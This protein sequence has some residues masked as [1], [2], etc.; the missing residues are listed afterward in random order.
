VNIFFG[1]L[2]NQRA[3]ID[4]SPVQEEETGRVGVKEQQKEDARRKSINPMRL[5]V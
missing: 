5:T 1:Y 3:D 2:P 4:L